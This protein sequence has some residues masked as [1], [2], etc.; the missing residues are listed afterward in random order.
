MPPEDAPPPNQRTRGVVGAVSLS[1]AVAAW[2]VLVFHDQYQVAW[3]GDY[4]T[5]SDV[6]FLVG[7]AGIV[8]TRSAARWSTVRSGLIARRFV[9][10]IVGIAAALL[11]SEYVTRFVFRQATSSGNPADYLARRGG[12]P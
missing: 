2:L 10:L 9:I 1:V 5:L 6:L 4:A 8:L 12:G 7:V 3:L 11:V